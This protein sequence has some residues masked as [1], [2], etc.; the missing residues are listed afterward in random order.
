[1]TL[2]FFEKL[3]KRC[4]AVDSLLCIGLDPH[5]SELEEVSADG[6]FRFCQRLVEATTEVA[7]AY[8][9]NAAFFEVFGSA[10]WDALEKTCKLIPKDIPII[11]DAKRGD[12]GST[13]EAYARAAF[14]GLGADCVTVSPYLGG[15]G[16]E[17][18]LKDASK[19]A[20]VLCKT[21]NPGSEDLQ[22]LELATGEP[23]YVRV[24]K[25]CCEKWANANKNAGLV[26]GATDVRALEVLRAALP[27]VWFL[28]PGVG[29]QGGDLAAALTAGLRPDGLGI[30][31]PISRG[32]SKAK[33]PKKAARDF[34]EDM[35]LCR[36][37]KAAASHCP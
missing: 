5:A 31:L 23:L 15:D 20:F 36:D 34:W 14:E 22:A 11:L 30:L 35:R 26:V 1:M 3:T 32:I 4:Q 21:S 27:D 10:G 12:I 16:V 37:G 7:A 6:A 17:P 13:S 9:P 28:S 33:D 25:V 18:F 19:G 2:P 29:A 24:A 8:K